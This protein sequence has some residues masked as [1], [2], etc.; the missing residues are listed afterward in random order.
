MYS[1]PLQVA[2]HVCVPPIPAVSFVMLISF[3]EQP[4][5]P[6][7]KSRDILGL[8]Q[9]ERMSAVANSVKRAIFIVS[10]V[11]HEGVPLRLFTAHLCHFDPARDR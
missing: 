1:L 7:V 6:D 9:P 10:P 11:R 4:I 5:C 3:G 2:V 8:V